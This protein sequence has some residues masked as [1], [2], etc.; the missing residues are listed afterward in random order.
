VRTAIEPIYGPVGLT[1]PQLRDFAFQA[2]WLVSVAAIERAVR[3][4]I[5]AVDGIGAAGGDTP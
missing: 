4:M 5:T 2:A 1:H 3:E